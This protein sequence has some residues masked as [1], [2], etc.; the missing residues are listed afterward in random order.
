MALTTPRWNEVA[1]R[2]RRQTDNFRALD[3][4]V[5]AYIQ[6]PFVLQT[7]QLHAAWHTW[8]AKFT[9]NDY[10]RSDR[11]RNNCALDD[12]DALLNPPVVAAVPPPPP[13]P[14]APPPPVPH[15]PPHPVPHA[16]PPPVPHAPPPQIPRSHAEVLAANAALTPHLQ[17]TRWERNAQGNFQQIIFD[18]EQQSSCTCA[19][20]ITMHRRLG[21]A[22][23]QE[24]VFRAKFSELHGAHDFEQVGSWLPKI[25]QTLGALGA[26]VQHHN[27]NTWNQL[28]GFLMQA[29]RQN[30]VM[31]VIQW[32]GSNV[33]HAVLCLGQSAGGGFE[34]EDPVDH[35]SNPTM[36][37]NGHYTVSDD[38]T[39]ATVHATAFAWAGCIVGK[40][41]IREYGQWGRDGFSYT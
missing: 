36:G 17:E 19:C 22:S 20:A 5:R 1:N 41:A 2:K 40:A 11:Y 16:P 7:N 37:D 24:H 28:K 39:G 32:N 6:H 29:T 3:Q 23:L 10:T 31:M 15:A 33:T 13:A 27:T 30:P 38:I 35:Y 8:I 34:M 18:Q 9:G 26:D 21:G 25:A 12:I 14:H 4:A